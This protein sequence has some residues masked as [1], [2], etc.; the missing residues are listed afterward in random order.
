M[1]KTRSELPHWSDSKAL[2]DRVRRAPALALALDVDGTLAPVVP[3]PRD[4]RIPDPTRG[5]LAALIRR[6]DV[7]AA[8][9]SGRRLSELR[10]LVPLPGL[11]LFAEYGLRV[12]R[13]EDVEEDPAAAAARPALAEARRRL[14][15]RAREV[16]GAWVEQK[17][18]DVVLHFRQAEDSA[19]ARLAHA[20][21]AALGDL[22]GPGAPLRAQRARKAIEVRPAAGPTKGDAIEYLLRH[23]PDALPI[24]IGDDV[25]D[26]PGF[27]Q[28]ARRGGFGIWVASDEV[29]DGETHA[30]C[31]L[32]GPDEVR[33]WLIELADAREEERG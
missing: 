3:V 29:A 19:A 33:D 21:E 30:A 14:E 24:F 4:A 5:A 6:P 8:A 23:R 12:A 20:A 9:V 16:P 31:R 26:E 25:G 32:A 15:A 2:R 22:V 7:T 11:V 10:S 17:D 27:A 18:V 1:P 13:G 28:A